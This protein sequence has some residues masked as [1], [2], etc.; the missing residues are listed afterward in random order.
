MGWILYP[1]VLVMATNK[2]VKKSKK[3]QS[4]SLNESILQAEFSRLNVVRKT[5]GTNKKKSLSNIILE[6]T[7]KIK[8]NT[9]SGKN[10]RSKKKASSI[11]SLTQT[12]INK[13]IEKVKET[14]K[15]KNEENK[16]IY[17]VK[18]ET[19]ANNGGYGT[20]SGVYGAAPVAKYANYSKLF[21]HLGI[22]KAKGMYEH[23]G[24]RESDIK[25]ITESTKE[26]VS[27]E[28]MEKA[29]KHFKYFVRGDVMGDVGYIPPVG[30]GVNSK[31]WEK[32]RLMSQMSI[33]QPIIKL[34]STTA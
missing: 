10:N 12:L 33:Y 1:I 14:K 18:E 2:R 29:A 28:T 26:M 27:T 24:T 31:D 15:E 23:L 22:F 34:K 21:S 20:V 9:P 19:Q 8:V 16:I 25:Q 30:I 5:K 13:A 6:V 4:K 11:C 17:S 7:S 32:Y 3:R